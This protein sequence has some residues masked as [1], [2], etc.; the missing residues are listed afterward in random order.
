M[1]QQ[2]KKQKVSRENFFY[3]SPSNRTRRKKEIE[4]NDMD[5]GYKK[6]LKI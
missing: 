6:L 3:C 2:G 5:R 4:K 1:E